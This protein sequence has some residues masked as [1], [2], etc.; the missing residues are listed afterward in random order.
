MINKDES[1]VMAFWTGQWL[2]SEKGF[3]GLA[4]RANRQWSLV[5]EVIFRISLIEECSYTKEELIGADSNWL[6]ALERIEIHG[7]LPSLSYE[8]ETCSCG[9]WK[10][11]G[12]E[13]SG[14]AS[15]CSNYDSYDKF[16]LPE[17]SPKNNDGRIF[18]LI[19]GEKTQTVSGRYQLCKN[20]Q[21][22]WY[23]N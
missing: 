17:N 18:C 12:K 10:M 9:S 8:G 23:E 14:H 22:R 20:N 11:Y 4:L 3:K 19:C 21:C 16:L 2:W 1:P 5:V 15:D 6:K 7:L 13:Y